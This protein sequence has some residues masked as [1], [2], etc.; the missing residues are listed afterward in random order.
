M[1]KC[2]SSCCLSCKISDLKMKTT[3]QYTKSLFVLGLLLLGGLLLA[4]PTISPRIANYKMDVELDIDSKRLTG[5]TYLHWK[6]TGATAVDHLL[7]HMYYNAFRNSESTFFKERGVPEFLTKDIDAEC[8]WGWTHIL[9]IQDEYG[10][11]LTDLS[12]IQTDDDNQEDKTVLKVGLPS[13]IP[14]GGDLTLTYEWVAKIPKTMPRTGYNKE[15]YFFAQWFPKVGVYEP[16]GMRYATADAWNCHQYHSQGEYYSDFGNYE[17]SMTVPSNY[18][19]ASSGIQTGL[20]KESDNKTWHFKVDDVIDFTWAASPHLVKTSDK[21]GDTEINLYTYP[22]KQHLADRYIPTLK[23][24]MQYLHQTLG[25]YPYP[26]IS[27]VD[28]P[29]HGMYTGGMEYPTLITSLSFDIFPDGIKTA[30]TLVVHE[31]IHQYF[32][33]MIATHEVEEPWMDEGFTTYFEGRILSSYLGENTSTIDFLGMKAGNREWNRTE[34]FNSNPVIAS[35]ARKSWQY[36]HGGYGTVSYNKTALW[37]ETMEGLLGVQTMDEIFKTYFNRWK[38]KHP[39]RQDFIN[40]VNEITIKNHKEQFPS[41]MDWYLDQVLYGTGLCDYA[42]G[43][44]ENAKSTDKRGFFKDVDNCEKLENTYDG[45][46]STLILNRLGEVT[47]PVE[48]KVTLDNGESSLYPWDGKERS[49]EIVIKGPHK[50]ISAE[51]DPAKKIMLDHNLL[52]NLMKS[53]PNKGPVKSLSARLV[54]FF[55]HSLELISLLV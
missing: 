17:V 33:Q 26:T 8:G 49:A 3:V 30:E 40:V 11:E 42:V 19:V 6:N 41:G 32:M 23:Y 54:T 4:Q 36:K 43:S 24:C 34:F 52:N 44:I 15:F 51:I 48:V 10:N 13:P 7:F 55:Q 1:I 37:L 45:Y 47:L 29:I 35:N 5:K 28:P 14:A 50:I 21:Y 16:T 38:F 25:E 31:F 18:V 46:T 53:K 22:D 20:E 12:Y 39:A 27:V 9:S 2:I